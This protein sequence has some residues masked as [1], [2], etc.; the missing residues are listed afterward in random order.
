MKFV[1]RFLGLILVVIGF[2][3]LVAMYSQWHVAKLNSE[4]LA[5]QPTHASQQPEFEA[6]QQKFYQEQL[7]YRELL[8]GAVVA[9]AF[10]GA[11]LINVTRKPI[12]VL[13]AKAQK[14]EVSNDALTK[15]LEAQNKELAYQAKVAESERSKYEAI[16]NS[17]GDGMLI[18]DVSGNVILVNMPALKI[19]G[20]KD[21]CIHGKPAYDVVQLYD[22]K[23][24][25][26]SKE[27]HP[28]YLALQHGQKIVQDLTIKLPASETKRVVRI[29]ATVIRSQNKTLGAVASLRDI[30]RETQIDRMKTEFISLA[31]HQLRTPLSAIR[32]FSEMLYQGDAGELKGEQKDYVKNIVDSTLRMI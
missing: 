16:I 8:L 12:A 6:L 30:T 31:S 7:L 3:G 21:D 26:V 11:L 1:A 17:L 5:K 22:D 24:Q 13:N 27:K 25:I 29:S 18:S 9:T 4:L 23:D 32:W 19:M 15:D 28:Q 14:L 2:I 10:I 20:Y